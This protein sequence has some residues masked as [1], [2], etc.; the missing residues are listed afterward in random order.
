VSEQSAGLSLDCFDGQSTAKP[1]IWWGKN[2]SFL[3]LD[4]PKVWT[5]ETMRNYR[6]VSNS[7][8]A[9]PTP[10]QLRPA[11]GHCAVWSAAIFFKA[12]S[13]FDDRVHFFLSCFPSHFRNPKVQ[14]PVRS[15]S[16]RGKK[17][18][19]A[20]GPPSQRSPGPRLLQHSFG[21]LSL[22]WVGGLVVWYVDIPYLQ[23]LNLVKWGDIETL[24]QI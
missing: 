10:F 5:W 2:T 17:H 7:R 16:A 8:P 3:G 19:V 6:Y 4:K 11:R 12:D 21:N 1:L 18:L 15:K 14:L 9:C 13:W 24:H 22:L 23:I 20:S